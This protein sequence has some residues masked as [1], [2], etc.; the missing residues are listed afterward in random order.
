M[1]PRDWAWEAML[2][3]PLP[4]PAAVF[5]VRVNISVMCGQCKAYNEPP[6]EPEPFYPPGWID[7]LIT[8]ILLES[9]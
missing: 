6:P 7:M 9:S 2:L 8:S 5:N 1:D 4:V 3:L